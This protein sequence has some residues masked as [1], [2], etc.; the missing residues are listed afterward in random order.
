MNIC[1]FNEGT[2]T[3]LISLYF[4]EFLFNVSCD[5]EK[6]CNIKCGFEYDS[7]SAGDNCLLL[8]SFKFK[9]N[10]RILSLPLIE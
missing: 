3:G 1:V 8:V 2:L 10:I 6:L 5:S 7:F 4:C 9:S